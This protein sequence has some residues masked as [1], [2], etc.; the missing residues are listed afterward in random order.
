[1]AKNIYGEMFDQLPIPE[2]LL[3]ENIAKML[4]EQASVVTKRSEI[5][6]SESSEKVKPITHS[7]RYR[8]IMS[9]AACAI[10]V[11][12]LIRF[13]ADDKPAVIATDPTPGVYAED[14]D[15]LHKTFQ[16]YYVED[17]DSNTLDSAIAEIEH[18]YNESKENS[19]TTDE[20]KEPEI[21]APIT[22]STEATLPSDTEPTTETEIPES[23]E[24]PSESQTPDIDEVPEEEEEV[25]A[26]DTEKAI[27]PNIDGYNTDSGIYAEGNRIYLREG[28]T[29]KVFNTSNGLSYEVEISPVVG[30]GETKTLAD[31]FVIGDKIAL[32]YDVETATVDA[33]EAPAVEGSTLDDIIGEAYTEAPE[34]VIRHSTELKLY[35]LIDGTV[36]E[37]YTQSQAGSFVEA[38]MCDGC[39]YI[40]TDYNDYRL[41]PIVGVNDLESYVPTYTVNGEKR[42]IEASSI[43]IPSK[44]TTTDYTVISGIDTLDLNGSVQALLG[45]EGRVIATEEAVYIFGYE[46]DNAAGTAVEIFALEG[47][48]VSHKGFTVI[49]GLALSGDGISHCGDGILITTVSGSEGGFTTTVRAYDESLEIL[50]KVDFPGLLTHLCKDG[51]KLYIGSDSVSYGVD[52]ADPMAPMLIEANGER[53]VTDSLVAFGDGY[54]AL[55]EAEGK[56]MLSKIIED[57]DGRLSNCCETVVY[58][59]VFTSKALE[60]NALIYT[61]DGIVGVPY[62]YF[63]GLDYCYTYVLYKSTA[64][65]FELVGSFETHETDTAFE[66]GMG[67]EVNGD[68]YIFSEGRV[69]RMT[70][71]PELLVCTNRADLIYSTYSGH[72]GF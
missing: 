53:D 15:Q 69:Y 51:S 1:M 17:E 13:T 10:L 50:S 68:L 64:T 66:L 25:A 37:L 47:G 27:L 57:G 14:Y 59:G 52:F 31:Y 5:T 18:A 4:D 70:A 60:N 20:V 9:V 3:P 6:V 61:G 46:A 58:E 19:E 45:Y 56:L 26:P 24:I 8:A 28:D 54:I 39:V 65:G 40:V 23:E 71:T 7:V 16:Q 67:I 38:S 33:V 49:D 72:N 22:D 12:G 36:F 44:V 48:A 55:Y 42:Y 32:V 30:L 11:L 29:V 41:S 35:Q 21:T 34:A 43:L 2:R 63:D 62:G